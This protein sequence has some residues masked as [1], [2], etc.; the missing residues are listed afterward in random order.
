[1]TRSS[2]A[3]PREPNRSKNADCGLTAATWGA[4][5]S[6]A[7]SANFS[8]PLTESVRP[9]ASSRRGVRVDAGAQ[10]PAAVHRGPQPGAE[11]L[12]SVRLIGVS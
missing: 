8:S 5:A 7:P 1:M 4:S 2:T 3:M 10:R 12:A 6:A 11:G 9:Q